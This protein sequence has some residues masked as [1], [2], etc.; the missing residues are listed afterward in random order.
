[1]IQATRDVDDLAL[2]D[3]VGS[4]SLAAGKLG[5]FLQDNVKL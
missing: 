1:M 2:G 4:C 5:A 3:G